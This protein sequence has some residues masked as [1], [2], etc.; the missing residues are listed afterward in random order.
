MINFIIDIF[1][2]TRLFIQ[3]WFL[4]LSTLTLQNNLNI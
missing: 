1:L 4:F 2:D 3:W